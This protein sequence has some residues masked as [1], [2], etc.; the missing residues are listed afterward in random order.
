MP[1]TEKN[2]EQTTSGFAEIIIPLALPKNYTWSIPA[3]FQNIVKPGIRA[4]VQLKNKR[5]SGIIKQIIHEKPKEFEPRPLHNILDDEPQLYQEQLQLWKWIADYYMCSEGEVMQAAMPSNLKLSSETILVWNEEHDED[6]T[7]L[8]DR[9]YIVAEALSIKKELKLSEVQELLD[10]SQ[11]YPVIKKLIEKNVCHV[12]EELKE[13]YKE[14]NETYII[15]HPQYRDEEKLS[16]LLNTSSRAPK[17]ME[18]LLSYLHLI[19][20]NNEVTQSELLKKS[21]ATTAQ[22]KGLIDKNILLAEK[23]SI[24]RIHSLPKNIFI[25]FTLSAAQQKSLTEIE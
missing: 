19:K 16:E 22:L 15:L 18:L 1:S 7:N 8:N 24:N 12:W 21:N 6:F 25:D 9:E 10:S 14:K 3:Q 23:R 13:K 20:N 5:Y 11:V 2:L 17:Q 4:E